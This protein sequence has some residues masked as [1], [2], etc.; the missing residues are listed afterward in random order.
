MIVEATMASA[1]SSVVGREGL[2]KRVE[3][4]MTQAIQQA[5]NDG[6]IDPVEIKVRMMA[7]RDVVRRQG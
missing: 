2:A 3:T 5:A 6:V 4:A 7:A 1:S